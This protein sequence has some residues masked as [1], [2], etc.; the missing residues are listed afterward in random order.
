MKLDDKRWLQNA[1]IRHRKEKYAATLFTILTFGVELQ[2]LFLLL[3]YFRWFIP[4]NRT[5]INIGASIRINIHI[6]RTFLVRTCQ[7]V[8]KYNFFYFLIINMW[9]RKNVGVVAR[10]MVIYYPFRVQF[11]RR[12]I[13]CTFIS[14][15][16]TINRIMRRYEEVWAYTP[17]PTFVRRWKAYF[18][19]PL[20]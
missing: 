6:S 3:L 15:L 12:Y 13:L 11:I 14:W 16:V 1:M 4:K 7:I 19:S 9:P 20:F 17:H 18:S 8:T 5:I 2:Y 10:V